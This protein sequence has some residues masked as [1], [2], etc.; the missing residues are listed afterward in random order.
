MTFENEKDQREVL[1][2]LSVGMRYIRRNIVDALDDPK[3]A[4]Q[5]KVL[6]ASESVEPNSV[7]WQDLNVTLT[8][9]VDQMILTNIFTFGCIIVVSL[10]V[11]AAENYLPTIGAAF[12]IAGKIKIC[13]KT[14]FK[15]H[16]T[17]DLVFVLFQVSI[18]LFQNSPKLLRPLRHIRRIVSSSHRYTSRLQ[19][20]V[21]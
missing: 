14:L 5:G 10:I 13:R 2:K 20:F 9:R 21:G 17:P 18:S 15:S 12:C 8:Q 4:F 11:N 1:A 7:R 16:T 3:Y 6:N 19:F